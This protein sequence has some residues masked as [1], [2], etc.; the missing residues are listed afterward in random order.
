M[1]LRERAWV[2]VALCAFARTAQ[3][4]TNPD[5][6][7]ARRSFSRG[8]TLTDEGD[9]GGAMAEFARAYELTRNPALLF[10]LAV[11]HEGMRH[12]SEALS[13][14]ER[15]VSEAPRAAVAARQT[16]VDAAL[17]RLRDRVGALIVTA[18]TPGLVI[19]VD[20]LARPAA[21]AGL[22]LDV[23]RHRVRLSAPDYLPRETEVEVTGGARVSIGEGLER[24]R[25]TLAVTCNV[26]GASVLVDGAP[27][28]TTPLSSPLV[29]SEG[30]HRVE[31]RRSGYTAFSTVVDAR[32]VGATVRAELA[33]ATP[34]PDDQG[35]RLV[36]R[37]SESGAAAFLDERRFS[38]DGS[39]S[40]P[41]GPHSLRVTRRDF[42]PWEASIDLPS[43][44]TVTRDVTLRPTALFRDEY[45]TGARRAR[46]VAWAVTG[47]GVAVAALGVAAVVL[48]IDGIA[49]TTSRQDEVSRE[50]TACRLG[51]TACSSST[52]GALMAEDDAL[53]RDIDQYRG[54]LIG[55]AVAGAV[56]LAGVVVGAVLLRRAPSLTRFAAS[57]DPR[58]ASLTVSF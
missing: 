36:L 37:V 38:F 1:H 41:S 34:V 8:V 20:G 3:A 26:G 39:E 25:S 16:D 19:E 11:V 50:L 9:Y 2:V 21:S 42:L 29:V 24:V 18:D 4:Q 51:V 52:T 15:F 35:A 22:R 23:G 17:A 10:N 14:F 27:V 47:A 28:A 49:R 44:A 33:W 31:L 12:W 55:G 46:T 45:L 30:E 43:G 40:V 5:E 54:V 13:T 7:E 6:G 57:V 56:G 53:P 32:G 58:G 48:G